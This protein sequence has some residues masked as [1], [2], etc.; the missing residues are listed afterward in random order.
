MNGSKVLRTNLLISIILIIGFAF[1][2]VFSYRANYQASLDNIEHVSSLTA[3]GIYYQLTGMFTRP[4]NISLTMAHDSL[5]LNHLVKETD[6]LNDTDYVETTKNYLNAYREKYGFDSV[7]LVS[8]ATRRYYNFSG[9][10]RVLEKGNPEN[11][12]YFDLL[13]NDLEYSLAVDNDEVNG[14][15]NEITVFVNCKVQGPDGITRGVVGVGIRIKHLKELLKGYEEKFGVAASLINEKGTIEIS[16]TYTGYEDKNWFE[17]YEKQNI[18]QQILNWREDTKN[19]EIWTDL[20]R[21]HYERS[22]VVIRYIPELSWNLI[23]EQN[24]GHLIHEMY[25][26]LY[27]TCFVLAV[28][29]L[30]VVIIVTTV[31]R[32]FNRQITQL[33]EER[34]SVF[35]QA[36]EQLYDSINELNLTKNCCVGKKTE[37]YFASLGA[38]GIPY[39]QGLRVIAQ[40][41]IKEE[42]REGYVTMFTPAN[43]IREYEE[44]NNHLQYDFMLT[45][46]G[47]AYCWTRIDAYMFY[48]EEDHSI[49]MFTYRK[50][51]D[52]E[53]KKELQ[54]A[55]D[56]MTGFFTKVVTERLID[57][58]LSEKPDGQ[59]AFFIF[60]IDNF[61]QANDQFGHAFGDFCIHCFTDIIRKCFREGDILGR[62]GGDEFGAFISISDPKIAEEKAKE[63]SRS[64]NTVCSK[65]SISWHMSAS[66]GVAL[67]SQPETTFEQLYQ[68]ADAALYQSKQN[69]KNGFTLYDCTL[70]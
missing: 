15:N 67:T 23:V 46:D 16:T 6:S 8:T 60:D 4:V 12:W 47:A 62:L 34:K 11:T 19:L 2:A 1:T 14:A 51:I 25:V 31:I 63:L 28:V 43:A 55:T 65:Q 49:H 21:H 57:R 17:V 68:R 7:F 66:I 36:T 48:S 37:E 40:K 24:T 54:A 27:Q 70:K 52:S 69:G 38:G 45:M 18:Q 64:L 5:L 61:K 41:Q 13:D 56:E 9:I 44:G 3:E 35:Q 58:C 22:F 33:M 50:N 53:K 20:D 29:I 42:H 10:D 26:Q 30:V 59:Y 32:N 39:D